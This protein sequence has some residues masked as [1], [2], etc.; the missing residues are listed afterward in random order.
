MNGLTVSQAA[1]RLGI[2]ERTVQRRCKNG[3]LS[4][5]LDTTPDGAQWL[6]DPA[7]LPTCAATTADKVPTANHSQNVPKAATGADTADKVP[8]GD[9]SELLNHLR[10]ENAFLRGLVE[11]RDRDAAELRATLRELTKAMPKALTE[12]DA[13]A[14]SAAVDEMPLNALQS[15]AIAPG[16]RTADRSTKPPQTGRKPRELTA[17]ARVIARITGIR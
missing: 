17:W 1:A 11:Q 5:R 14:A 16:D 13:T 3:Q 6:I 7:T 8:T 15:P 2:S 10:G 9:D 12:G 4:A